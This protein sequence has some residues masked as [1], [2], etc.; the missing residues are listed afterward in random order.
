MFTM[1]CRTFCRVDGIA[2]ADKGIL[3]LTTRLIQY[4]EISP[5]GAV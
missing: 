5:R 2:V 4:A 3:G 1:L